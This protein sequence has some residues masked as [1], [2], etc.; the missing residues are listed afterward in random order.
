MSAT[1]LEW[2]FILAFFLIVV[3]FMF[4]EAAWL[5][6]KGWATFGKSFAFSALS[7]FIGFAVGLFVFFIVIG[8]FLMFSLDGTTQRVFDSKVGSIAGT[9]FIVF[10]TILTPLLL[11]ICKRIFLS[12]L[13]MQTGKTAWLFA[14]ASSG[15]ILVFALGLP[16]LIGYLIFR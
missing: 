7:N 9:V 8:L 3:G 14:L 5:S 12:A 6:K 2:I 11:I 15:L 1:L 13:K 10:A 4:G 16:T